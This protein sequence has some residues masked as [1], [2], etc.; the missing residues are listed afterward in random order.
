LTVNV[1]FIDPRLARVELVPS[2]WRRLFLRE[3]ARVLFVVVRW[4]LYLWEHNDTIVIDTPV[5]DALRTAARARRVA[6][7]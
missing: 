4:T 7:N 1:A 6:P 3:S 2:W 5:L